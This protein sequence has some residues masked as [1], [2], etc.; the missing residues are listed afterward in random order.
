MSCADVEE[1]RR[2]SNTLLWHVSN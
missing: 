1:N 2:R